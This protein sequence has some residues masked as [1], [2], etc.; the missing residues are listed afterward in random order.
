MCL[1]TRGPLWG[2]NAF[3]E[4]KSVSAGVLSLSQD[5]CAQLIWQS[6]R[7]LWI[8]PPVEL[9]A[10]H[11]FLKTTVSRG[12]TLFLE[13]PHWC[14]ELFP[15]VYYSYRISDVG[16]EHLHLKP[17]W[18]CRCAKQLRGQGRPLLQ[19]ICSEPKPFVPGLAESVPVAMRPRSSFLCQASTHFPEHSFGSGGGMRSSPLFTCDF[20]VAVNRRCQMLYLFK[21]RDFGA[22]PQ[23]FLSAERLGIGGWVWVICRG[24]HILWARVLQNGLHN[25]LPGLSP[26]PRWWHLCC[27][28][29][30]KPKPEHSE[31]IDIGEFGNKIDWKLYCFFGALLRNSV[32]KMDLRTFHCHLT[33]FL[34]KY[35]GKYNWGIALAWVSFGCYFFFVL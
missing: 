16:R 27:L 7:W 24:S 1:S 31:L 11:P 18:P 9:R 6:G 22:K 30:R 25:C 8:L 13:S 33:L 28:S 4:A 21:P 3:T 34:K 15:Y 26:Q 5:R 32:I 2:R 23:I 10:V 20:H 19:Q 29:P 35:F 17:F 12:N 14:D